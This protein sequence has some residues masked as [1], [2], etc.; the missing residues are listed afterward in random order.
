LEGDG[1]CNGKDESFHSTP[2]HDVEVWNM[3]TNKMRCERK[4]NI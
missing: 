3:I 2:K 1:G 4:G